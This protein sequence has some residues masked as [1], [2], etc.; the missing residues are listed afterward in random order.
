MPPYD[1]YNRE[2]RNACFH[3]LRL[4]HEPDALESVLTILQQ[5]K[6]ISADANL[7]N[8]TRVFAGYFEVALIR[9]AY[10]KWKPDVASFMD[11]LVTLIGEQEGVESFRKYSELPAEL[12]DPSRT[13]PGKLLRKGIA[14]GWLTPAE[15]KIYRAVQEFFHA[16]PDLAIVLDALL[17][18]F[19]AKLTQ[20]F[21]REQ[22]MRTR[23]I[24][25]VWSRLLFG[26]LGFKASPTTLVVTLGHDSSGA[27]LTW[28]QLARVAAKTYPETDRARLCLEHAASLS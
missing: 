25:E 27:A 2:E 17:I 3:V 13:Y 18:V 22:L 5:G 6:H 24:A 1:K 10:R 28:Q 26:E 8:A 7:F 12:C 21:D 4:L 19:E 14:R 23:K 11:E 9:D 16:K 15:L 20:E